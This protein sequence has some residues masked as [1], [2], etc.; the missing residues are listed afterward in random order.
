MKEMTL[1]FKRNIMYNEFNWKFNL[2]V[3]IKVFD[4]QKKL[5]KNG[6]LYPYY[7][8]ISRVVLFSKM[9]NGIFKTEHNKFWNILWNLRLSINE[10]VNVKLMEVEC[11]LTLKYITKKLIFLFFLRSHLKEIY[12]VKLH[13][14]VPYNNKN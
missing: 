1:L 11:I 3:D 14:F 7:F 6:N 9:N 4:F 13:S 8:F 12:Y 10:I 2:R 5:G